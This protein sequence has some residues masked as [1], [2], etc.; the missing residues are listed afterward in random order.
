M[1]GIHNLAA[2]FKNDEAAEKT[3]TNLLSQYMPTLLQT[4]LQVVDREDAVESNLRIG[5]F[6]AMSVL[7]QNS[8]PDVLNVLMQLLPAINDRLG[9]SFN[10][11]CL[12]N[13]DKEQKEGIQGLLCGLIQVI[14][15]KTTKEAIL[16]FCDSIM[17][18]FLQVLQTKNATCHEEALSATS[19]IA[20]ILEGDS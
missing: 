2:A 4:L 9:Q 7:I 19:A 17:T 11:P 13:E 1:L 16:P 20:T 12:T 15:I 6:E 8:A 10:M 3:G 18:N 14:A 5:A